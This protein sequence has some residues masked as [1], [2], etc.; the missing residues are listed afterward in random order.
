VNTKN[1][2]IMAKQASSAPENM[3]FGDLGVIRNIL[4]GEQIAKIDESLANQNSQIDQLRATLAQS[5]KNFGNVL[6]KLEAKVN[7]RLDALELK[8]S[9]NEKQQSSNLKDAIASERKELSTLLRTVSE[10]L[11]K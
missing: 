6:A 5:E 3:G 1:D 2:D 4:M 7:E 9:Q 8:L 11:G 10:Q